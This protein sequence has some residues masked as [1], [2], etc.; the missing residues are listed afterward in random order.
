[1]KKFYSLVLMAAALLFGTNAWAGDITVTYNTGAKALNPG[2]AEFDDLQLAINSIPAG[3]SATIVLNQTIML[4]NGILIPHVVPADTVGNP[5]A[6]ILNRAAQRICIDLNGKNIQTKTSCDHCCIAL[7]KGVLRL[8]GTGT[9]ERA[10]VKKG[11]SNYKRGAILVSGIDGD[12][13]NASNDRSKQTWSRLYVDKDVTVKST[14]DDTYA[15]GIQDLGK[16]APEWNGF[17]KEC[18]GYTTYY[19]TGG[20]MWAGA[21]QTEQYSAFGVEIFIEGTLYGHTRGVNVLGNLNQAPKYVEGAD[22]RKYETY[23][24]YDHRYPYVYIGSNADVSCT[25]NGINEN[26]NGGIY[27]GGWAIIDIHGEV[28]GQTGVFMKSGDV[29]LIDG[30]VYSTADGAAGNSGNYHGDVSGSGIFIASTNTSSGYVGE[31]GVLITGDSHV[32]GAGGSAIVDVLATDATGSKVTH[33]EITGGT[34]EGGD[35]GAINLTTGTKTQT[36]VTGGSVEGTVTVEGNTVNVTTLL[37]NTSSYHT[38]TVEDENGNTI[39]VVS[40]GAAPEVANLVSTATGSIKWQ[41]TSVKKDTIKS[42]LTL[43]ELEISEDYDQTLVIN[44]G[45]KLTVG[46]VVLGANAQIIVEAGAKLIVNG[47][48]GIVAP[49]TSNL[50]LR[51]QENNPAIF[52]FKPS[53]T[54]NRHPNATVEFFSKS[55]VGTSSYASQRF[56]VPV[57]NEM[58]DVDAV[59]PTNE[60]IKVK[61]RFY[62]FD[63]TNNSWLSLGGINGYT[64]EVDKSTMASPFA[65]YQMYNYVENPGTKVIMK[66]DLVGNQI[67]QLDILGNSWYGFANSCM[68][69]MSVP[70]LIDMIPNTVDKAIYLYDITADHA[71]WEPMTKLDEEEGLI[72]PMQPFL[73]RNTK[74]AAGINIDYADAVYYPTTG[75]TKPNAA[76]ARRSAAIDITKVKLVVNGEGCKDRV[77]VAE[78]DEF[79]ADFDNG[80]DAAKYM[81]DGINLYV[82]ANEK[83]SNYATDDLENTYVGFQAVKAGNYTI[84]FASVKGEELTLVDLETGARVAMI[85]G[86]TYEFTANE[87][88][89]YRFQIT[90]ISKVATDIENTEAVKS[91]TGIY[92]ITGQYMGEMNVWNTLPAGVYVVNGEKRVK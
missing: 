2:T 65:Y 74:E 89:D 50:I 62:T 1:M 4:D 23:P 45:K 37:P 33:V 17:K 81:N 24:Y 71:T 73:I 41:N 76:P 91:A 92:T 16:V 80:Y 67:P 77:I 70:E 20:P 10:N 68:G 36:E 58:V 88:N 59:D 25:S 15:I 11:D 83:M 87:A 75:E 43:T 19:A 40:Q 47:A 48:Q 53:V 5:S 61:T 13:N 26:G 56:G 42:D 60:S 38:T 21:G 28:Y 82:S 46:R 32:A 3:D 79:T 31:T 27:V 54:S 14:Y 29:K 9:V 22:K 30:N 51:T 78:S 86:N 6:L 84:E 63:Y 52:V 90:K 69:L 35:Q 66:G 85:E 64:P 18:A 49:V 12:R 8:T 55:Y 72:Q 39:I 44:T 34:I 7:M 57:Y